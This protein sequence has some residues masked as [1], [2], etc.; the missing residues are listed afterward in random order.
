MSSG[1]DFGAVGGRELWR[2]RRRLQAS[3]SE[4]SSVI[5]AGPILG[6]LAIIF[7][8]TVFELRRVLRAALAEATGQAVRGGPSIA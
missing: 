6:L 1:R 4:I 2:W 7:W 8:N 5:E 3:N